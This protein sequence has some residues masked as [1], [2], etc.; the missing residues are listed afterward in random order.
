MGVKKPNPKDL[1]IAREIKNRLIGIIPLFE[2]RLFGSRARGDADPDSDLDIYIETGPLSRPSRRLISEI[3]WEVGFENDVVI[4]PVVFSQEDVRDGP[5]SA[6]PLY[7]T[8][9]REGIP[10]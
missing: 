2:V 7:R 10:V 9:Q 5:L 6:S 3:T 1:A 8:I 4:V